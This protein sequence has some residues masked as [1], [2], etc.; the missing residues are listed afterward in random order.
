MKSS[1]QTGFSTSTISP[2]DEVEADWN[3]E[4]L[5]EDAKLAF[6]LAASIADADVTPTWYAGDEFEAVRKTSL[7]E[8][9]DQ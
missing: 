4:G 9:S 7:M 3:L 8:L 5:T 6:R 2:G 1:M